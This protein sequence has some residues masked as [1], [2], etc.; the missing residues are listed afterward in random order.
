MGR[1]ICAMAMMLITVGSGNAKN[2]IAYRLVHEQTTTT[3]VAP[4]RPVKG[5]VLGQPAAPPPAVQQTRQIVVHK[6]YIVIQRFA[7]PDTVFEVPAAAQTKMEEATK[8]QNGAQCGLPLG[9]ESWPKI[10]RLSKRGR[11]LRKQAYSEG[12]FLT[13]PKEGS[14]TVRVK[15]DK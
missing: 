8:L 9:W 7:W 3:I 5:A 6:Y 11:E 1:F 14:F 13:S 15:V 4:E 10:N 12:I 2:H